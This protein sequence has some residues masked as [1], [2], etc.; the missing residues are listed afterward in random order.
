MGTPIRTILDDLDKNELENQ[1][2]AKADSDHTHSDYASASD[3][4][5]VYFTIAANGAASITFSGTAN[6][7]IY[8]RGWNGSLAGMFNYSGYAAGASRQGL[9]TIVN[10]GGISVGLNDEAN[11][12]GMSIINNASNTIDVCVDV[13]IGSIPTTGTTS[14]S[15]SISSAETYLPL[16]GGTVTGALNLISSNYIEHTFQRNSVTTKFYSN[17]TNDFYIDNTTALGSQTI[18]LHGDSILS[19]SYIVAG[20]PAIG[21]SALRNISAGTSALTAGSSTLTTGTIYIQYE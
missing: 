16:S 4:K 20:N 8:C 15:S 2:N 19:S 17:G 21:T 3:V 13:M 10:H 12:Q 9:T 7:M 6:A 14:L 1:I 11:G 18:R 5:K